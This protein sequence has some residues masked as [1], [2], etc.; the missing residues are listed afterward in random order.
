MNIRHLSLLLSISI[1]SNGA[2]A[3]FSPVPFKYAALRISSSS[4]QGQQGAPYQLIPSHSSKRSTSALFQTDDLNKDAPN[5]ST[6]EM[7]GNEV[8][9]SPE[10]DDKFDTSKISD[11]LT[12][13][14]GNISSGEFGSRGEAYFVGQIALVLCIFYGNIPLVGDVITF[15]FGPCT[16]AIGAIVAGLGVKDLGSNLSPFP[17]VP[18]DTD[19]VTDGIFEEV[20]HPIYAGLL[21]LCL[22]ISIWSGSA[23]RMLLTGALWYLLDKKSD[24]EEKTLLDRFP[25]YDDYMF[26]VKGKFIPERLM[27]TMPW[28]NKD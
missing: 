2:Y 5:D 14:Y 8:A 17:K 21:Y 28:V 24:Y 13:I 16:C 20:R 26:D 1:A 3:A 22:G 11:L 9:V 19:L 10:K 27:E 7:N 23:M 6:A 12:K 25:S 18:S 4:H 15:I